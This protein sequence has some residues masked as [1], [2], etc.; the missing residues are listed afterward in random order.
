VAASIAVIL[1][2]RSGSQRA[3]E[4]R[5]F[6]EK[7]LK[8][9]GRSFEISVTSG[10]GLQ[11]LAREKAEGDAEVLVAAGGDGTICGVAEA[12][13]R[14]SKTL[15]V[16][17]LGTF[18]YFARNLGIPLD[19]EGAARTI[20]EGKVVRS[21]VLDLD[22][23]LVLNNA[24]F[25]I[26]RAV[27]LRRRKLNR[28]WGR[29][30]LNSYLSV[31]FSAFQ[32]APKVRVRLTTDEGELVRE[33]SLVMVCSNA[34]QM[35]TF[36][37]AGTNCLEAGKFALYIARGSGRKTILE[38]GLRALFRRLRP[39][40]DYE[41]ICSSDVTIESLRGRELHA[42]VDGELERLKSPIHFRIHPQSL[43]VLAPPVAT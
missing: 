40:V 20:L 12:A 17:P 8:A 7:A 18:N 13:M 3:K 34:Y 23:R 36:A 25:G 39:G 26:H 1:N 2:A 4:A 15:G 28:L 10:S 31:I 27:L 32:R 43:R 19:L 16:I 42:A 6:L 5:T 38:L 14:S 30:Q 11:R 41:V 29:H 33:T 24:S 21:S 9:S 35:E 37:L 22:G